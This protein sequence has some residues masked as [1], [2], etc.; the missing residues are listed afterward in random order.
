LGAMSFP[1]CPQCTWT[2][3][4]FHSGMTDLPI[5][6][7][8]AGLATIE[9]KIECMKNYVVPLFWGTSLIQSW[10]WVFRTQHQY[11]LQQSNEIFPWTHCKDWTKYNLVRANYVTLT[12]QCDQVRQVCLLDRKGTEV[13]RSM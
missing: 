1:I 6:P 3:L 7:V 13:P 12:R 9:S 8:V 4:N 10:A 5:Y 11:I 2:P